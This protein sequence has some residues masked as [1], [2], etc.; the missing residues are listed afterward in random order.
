MGNQ[1]GLTY[2]GGAL[3]SAVLYDPSE[4]RV[5][6]CRG[7]AGSRFVGLHVS[8][9]ECEFAAHLPPG[10]AEDLYRQLRGILDK[11]A[12]PAPRRAKRKSDDG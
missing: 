8:D 2:K 12:N 11:D 9:G 5:T 6:D 10:L 7:G 1:V 4:T 3:C